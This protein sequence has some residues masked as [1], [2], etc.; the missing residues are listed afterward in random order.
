MS[1]SRAGRAVKIAGAVK[2]YSGRG[3]DAVGWTEAIENGFGPTSA[4]ARSLKNGTVAVVAAPRSCSVNVACRIENQIAVGTV[5]V[6]AASECMQEGD[7]VAKYR[8]AERDRRSQIKEGAVPANTFEGGRTVQGAIRADGDPTVVGISS[9]SVSGEVIQRIEHPSGTG[10]GEFV[11][12]SEPAE[13]TRSALD[14]GSIQVSGPVEDWSVR[15]IAVNS[16][17][18][19]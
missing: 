4:R 5:T 12:V 6:V 7:G 3:I 11:D 13:F 10:M 1:A 2:N 9:I 15:Q 16:V 14:R 17:E 19:M 8:A 18:P